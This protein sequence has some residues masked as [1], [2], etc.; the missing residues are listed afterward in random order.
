MSTADEA[1]DIEP[2]DHADS[3]GQMVCLLSR[4]VRSVHAQ[5]SELMKHDGRLG[6]G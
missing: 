3:I 6:A 1:L 5:S 2:L 4:L